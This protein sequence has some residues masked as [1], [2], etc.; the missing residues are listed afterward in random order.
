MY[1]ID[2]LINKISD[3]EQKNKKLHDLIEFS[4]KEIE[5]LSLHLDI[6]TILPSLKLKLK[7][8]SK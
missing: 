5:F 7:E 2:E 4:F 3:L 6:S 8:L 1:K